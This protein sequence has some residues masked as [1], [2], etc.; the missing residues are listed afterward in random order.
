M[1]PRL[2]FMLIT[3][4]AI[5]THAMAENALFVLPFGSEPG[6]PLAHAYDYGE[7]P[8]REG[9]YTMRIPS[10]NPEMASIVPD[11]ELTIDAATKVVQRSFATR[12]YRALGDC[13]QA[14]AL[15]RD[16][17]QKVLPQAYS[18]ISEAWQF[19]TTDGKIL[20]GAYCQQ[21]RHL[22]FPTLIMELVMGPAP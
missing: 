1:P 11:V 3:T 12:A 5:T 10:V 13:K 21:A 17:L 9:S 20:G 15:L 2:L 14:E 19:Q 7:S 18:G 22:P 8:Q 4:L 16:K 6:A